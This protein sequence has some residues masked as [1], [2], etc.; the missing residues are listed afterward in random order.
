M[1]TTHKL[2]A[3]ILIALSLAGATAVSAQVRLDQY[4]YQR[5]VGTECVTD[6]GYG[7]FTPCNHGG[8]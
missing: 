8:G 7:R 6:E 2:T 5:P 3:A 1:T 4:N